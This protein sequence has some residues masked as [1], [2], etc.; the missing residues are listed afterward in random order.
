[1]AKFLPSGLVNKE[2]A[3]ISHSFPSTYVRGKV[4]QVLDGY[5]CR[6][7]KRRLVKRR[8]VKRRLVE[9]HLV[10]QHLVEQCLVKQCF[11]WSRQPAAGIR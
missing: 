8:L 4:H 3:K 1:M 7:V 11:P 5:Q 6:L 10:N 9:C 2:V